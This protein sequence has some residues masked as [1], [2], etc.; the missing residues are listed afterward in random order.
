MPLGLMNLHDG[1]R[2]VRHISTTGQ[3]NRSTDRPTGRLIDLLRNE[4]ALRETQT[5][6]A[7]CSKT[8]PKIPPAAADPTRFPGAQDGQNLISYGHYLQIQFGE[9][10]FTQFRVIVVIRPTN[11]QIHPQTHTQTHRQDRLQYTAPL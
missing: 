3:T 1:R 7:G 11:T 10:R 4:K 5:L 6:P 2:T 8:E 9:D